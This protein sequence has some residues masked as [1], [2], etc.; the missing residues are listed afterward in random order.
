[1]DEY[2]TKLLTWSNM[3]TIT[4]R[5]MKGDAGET[6]RKT[7]DVTD[8]PSKF[9]AKK[10]NFYISWDIL[11]S[12]RI[13]LWVAFRISVCWFTKMSHKPPVSW[14]WGLFICQCVANAGSEVNSTYTYTLHLLTLTNIRTFGNDDGTGQVHGLQ[15]GQGNLLQ[16]QA[17][18]FRQLQDVHWLQQHFSP[19][20]TAP[21][22]W[23]L[24]VTTQVN[25]RCSCWE[26]L[27]ISKYFE[28]YNFNY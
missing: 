22:A 15:L 25:R 4:I 7:M 5:K 27:F 20:H 9:I 24:H 2:L 18:C 21:G 19:A 17:L 23:A 26:S 10:Y 12:G 11:A 1:M 8:E 14:V 13:I 28:R 6:K 3:R 16:C